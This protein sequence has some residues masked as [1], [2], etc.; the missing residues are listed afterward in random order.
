M[1]R[2]ALSVTA[3]L[4][5]GFGLAL[6]TVAARGGD[7]APG[8]LVEIVDGGRVKTPDST[9]VY[10][11]DGGR[12]RPMRYAGYK[13]LFSGWGGIGIVVRV[14]EE[15]LGE[16]IRG[17]TRLVRIRDDERIWMVDNGAVLRE[18][19]NFRQA[20]FSAQKVEEVQPHEV[21]HLPIGDPIG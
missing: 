11:V 1:M 15:M 3:V 17:D 18:V 20:S 7:P 4:A 10:F 8:T 19:R 9:T 5:A 12:L 14:P 13:N 21:S 16:G 6:S 2:R